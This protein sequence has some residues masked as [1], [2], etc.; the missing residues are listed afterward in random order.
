MTSKKYKIGEKVD[1]SLLPE[2]NRR[3]IIEIS[4]KIAKERAE[5]LIQLKQALMDGRKKDAI[6]IAKRYCGITEE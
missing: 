1:W 6:E 5:I 3:R 2:A 4:L